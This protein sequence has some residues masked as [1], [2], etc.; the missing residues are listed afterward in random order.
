VVR[1][2]EVRVVFEDVAVFVHRVA[3]DFE[4]ATA[5]G[6]RAVV[7]EEAVIVEGRLISWHG[8]ALG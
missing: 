4:L 2:Q 5:A 3:F 7:E 8:L 1:A 6:F